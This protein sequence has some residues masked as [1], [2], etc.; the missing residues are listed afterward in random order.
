MKVKVCTMTKELMDFTKD[1]ILTQEAQA[2]LA[3]SNQVPQGFLQLL[4]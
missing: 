1:N 2:M 3:Q 4:R